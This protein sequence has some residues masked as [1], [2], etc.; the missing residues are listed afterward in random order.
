MQGHADRALEW[1]DKLISEQ[2]QALA[3]YVRRA[4]LLTAAGRYEDAL[5]ALD[6]AET[7]YN[8]LEASRSHPPIVHR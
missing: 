7:I 6:E 1:A 3:G 5:A 4:D 8:R 2:P